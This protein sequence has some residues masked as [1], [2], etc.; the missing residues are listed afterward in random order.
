MLTED[1]WDLF[2]RYD[3]AFFPFHYIISAIAVILVFLVIKKPGK[4]TGMFAN[5]FLMLCYLWIGAGFYL[6][7]KN[8]LTM[9]IQ[10]FQPVLMF[11][12]ALCFGIDLF[13]GRNGFRMPGNRLQKILTI[14]LIAY[15]IIGYPLMG[16]L[17]KHPYAVKTANDTLLWVPI[18]GA[19]PCPT[20]IF[21]IALLSGSLPETDRSALILLIIWAIFSIIGKPI[22]EYHAYEDIVL[23]LAGL[24]GGYALIISL[25]K[26][27]TK[28]NV[29]G[30][31]KKPL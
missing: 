11:L 2:N 8:E 14:S 7:Y 24:Y 18:L 15:S 19:Y 28:W 3:Q 9:R 20:T 5:L 31:A 30:N 1:E 17:L 23:F 10:Y 22:V 27:K 16:Y 25:I 21:A 12:I 13:R 6:I 26:E 4:R 29:F